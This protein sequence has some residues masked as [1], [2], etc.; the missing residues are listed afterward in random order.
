MIPDLLKSEICLFRD[1]DVNAFEKV[2]ERYVDRLYFYVLKLVKSPEIAEEIVQGVFVK[3]WE[4]RSKINLEL[5]FEAFIYR[6]TRNHTLNYLKRQAY[7]NRFKKQ[8]IPIYNK[9]VNATENHVILNETSK[10]IHQAIDK[11]PEKRQTIYRMSRLEG[12]DHDGIA[13]KLGI[14]K[15]TVKVQIVKASKFVKAFYV[16]YSL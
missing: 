14:S 13:T 2:Y 15:N 3:I 6:I 5:S 1:G 10:I 8:L 12:L 4:I 7:E 11:L 9:G 16:T